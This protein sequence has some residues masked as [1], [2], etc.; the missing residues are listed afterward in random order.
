M[1]SLINYIIR[2]PEDDKDK[3]KAFKYDKTQLNKN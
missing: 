2:V 3:K 1:K